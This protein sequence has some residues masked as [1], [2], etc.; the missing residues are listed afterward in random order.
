[1]TTPEAEIRALIDDF[2]R[3]LERK[4]ADALVATCDE[5]VLMFD[6]IPPARTRGRETL[7]AIWQACLPY[8]P[9]SFRCVRAEQ[10]IHASGDVAFAHCL[11]RIETP[12][13]NHPAARS[14]LRVT[15][16]FRKTGG[17]W[18]CTHAHVSLPFNP[19]DDRAWP[20][21]DPDAPPPDYGACT[22]P[23]EPRA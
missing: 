16:C 4:D 8:F 19:I 9:D 10:E 18:R 23:S 13:P 20:F 2:T 5:Q 6:A 12:D 3:A 1:M 17:A 7:R 11:Q 22:P 14:W 15:E 21:A